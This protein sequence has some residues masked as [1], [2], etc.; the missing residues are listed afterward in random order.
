MHKRLRRIRFSIATFSAERIDSKEGVVIAAS[1]GVII[2]I[3]NIYLIYESLRDNE[4]SN[5]SINLLFFIIGIAA[6]SYV[7]SAVWRIRVEKELDETGL[8]SQGTIVSSRTGGGWGGPTTYH[9]TYQYKSE[10][11]REQEVS[12]SVY[13]SLYS[14]DRVKIRYLARD[15]TITKMELGLE[16][17]PKELHWLLLGI[18]LKEKEQ[19]DT[20][21]SIR[22]MRQIFGMICLLPVLILP[23]ILPKI[24][25]VEH[26][27]IAIT[28]ILA[29]PFLIAFIYLGKRN[30]MGYRSAKFCSMILLLGF[31]IF[32]YFGI[33]YLKKLSHP[34][35]R[36]VFD[37]DS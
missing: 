2:S 34:E 26:I 4:W 28:L 29:I 3:A 33:N 37:G 14:G 22:E 13:E 32:T 1:I 15:P 23:V 11:E 19:I 10:Y 24:D 31:P 21:K 16:T 36:R 5:I 7:I 6:I 17:F 25:I 8:I 9:V 30:R 27:V 20:S 18:G 35:M 12:S